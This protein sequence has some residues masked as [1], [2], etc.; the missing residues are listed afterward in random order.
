MNRILYFLLALI[1]V[2][3][4]NQM[5]PEQNG[6]I[7]SGEEG[8]IS[9]AQAKETLTR[10]RCE[11]F[12][13]TRSTN[14]KIASC[15]AYGRPLKPTT[16][17]NEEP[18][19][20]VFNYEDNQGFAIMAAT[21]SLPEV[22]AISD[23]GNLDLANLPNNGIRDFVSLLGDYVEEPVLLLLEMEKYTQ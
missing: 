17:S 21:P 22:L 18:V 7:L 20:Y 2:S 16:R 13:Q 11:F 3:A 15:E 23:K 10:L 6:K 12:P 5:E 14:A 19:L 8:T 9:R 1:V 4:C